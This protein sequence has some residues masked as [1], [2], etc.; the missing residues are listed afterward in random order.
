MQKQCAANLNDAPTSA[1]GGKQHSSGRDNYKKMY[2]IID[3]KSVPENQ[4]RSAQTEYRCLKIRQ[5]TAQ[6][7]L[8]NWPSF[9]HC[10]VIH[11]RDDLLTTSDTSGDNKCSRVTQ[12]KTYQNRKN[13]SHLA[14][15]TPDYYSESSKEHRDNAVGP[16]EIRR[17][18]AAQ[19][20]KKR[21]GTEITQPSKVAN[22]R[23]FNDKQINV[24][25]LAVVSIFMI[26]ILSATFAVTDRRSELSNNTNATVVNET[27][28]IGKTNRQVAGNENPSV[29]TTDEIEE[30]ARTQTNSEIA[31]NV[32]SD[33]AA[34]LAEDVA[35]NKM[36]E[37]IQSLR[38]ENS[39]LKNAIAELEGETLKLNSELLRLELDLV[40]ANHLT[41]QLEES[42]TQTVYNF[43]NVPIGEGVG[44]S[45]PGFQ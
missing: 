15:H 39:L 24:S 20:P 2:A 37:Q 31:D 38:Q 6:N 32:V 27:P 9:A 19:I 34:D 13:R 41:K 30:F 11:D 44:S 21:S 29:A 36:N 12:R 10:S 42:R 22:G 45:I 14:Q 17:E 23:R 8:R 1:K 25:M 33:N 5:K 3:T 4:A 16:I 28:L 43:V 26:V 35:A 7:P 18:N 40:D